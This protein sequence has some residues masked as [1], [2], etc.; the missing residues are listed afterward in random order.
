MFDGGGELAAVGCPI[1]VGWVKW[2][3]VLDGRGVCARAN[4]SVD[5]LSGGGWVNNRG[6]VGG[7]HMAQLG[8]WRVHAG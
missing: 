5:R 7:F 6:E 8:S 3:S 1:E 4:G 2:R